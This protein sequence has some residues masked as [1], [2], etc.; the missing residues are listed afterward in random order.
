MAIKVQDH[1]GNKFKSIREMALFH[2][3]DPTKIAIYLKKGMTPKEA[4]FHKNNQH[5]KPVKDHLGNYYI[6]LREMCK[7][8]NVLPATFKYRTKIKG[9]SIKEALEDCVFENN[10]GKRFKTY[11]ALA[12]YYDIPYQQ[13]INNNAKNKNLLE[14]SKKNQYKTN[15]DHLGNK[16]S[17]FEEMCKNYKQNP[18][19]VIKRLY[20]KIPLKNALLGTVV[21]HKGNYYHSIKSMLKEYTIPYITYKT[22]INQDY[23]LEEILEGKEVDIYGNRFKTLKELC[24]YHN[25]DYQKYRYYK[26]TN[27][28]KKIEELYNKNQ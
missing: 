8:Y 26:H 2:G 4:L 22:Q 19:T 16:Y 6:N 14:K 5:Y 24:N 1:L 13:V 11:K 28:T 17:S 12:E 18:S 7:A 27:N 21:D 10:K 3:K 23:T 9:L 25:L 20:R 15:I